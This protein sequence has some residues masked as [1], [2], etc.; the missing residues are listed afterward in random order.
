MCWFSCVPKKR[1][2]SGYT[3][4]VTCL[5]FIKLKKRTIPFITV[6]ESM[7]IFALLSHFIHLTFFHSIFSHQFASCQL[8][9]VRKRIFFVL[10]LLFSFFFISICLVST[11]IR[12][13]LCVQNIC[14]DKLFYRRS[15]HSINFPFSQN[16]VYTELTV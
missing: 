13:A 12:M 10:L 4:A 14:S 1:V 5:H 9:L 6:D 16:S 3:A 15:V 2:F 7:V 8:P 11:Y